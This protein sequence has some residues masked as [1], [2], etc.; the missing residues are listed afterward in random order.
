M[1]GDGVSPA[2]FDQTAACHPFIAIPVWIEEDVVIV[3]AAPELLLARDRETVLGLDCGTKGARIMRMRAHMA[4]R[5]EHA[6]DQAKI[7]SVAQADDLFA[8]P[9]GVVR[10][11]PGGLLHRH[12]ETA[13]RR[14]LAAD[15]LPPIE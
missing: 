3:F 10:A 11:K 8:C 5:Q 12:V 2:R 9:R 13:A 1:T 6:V 7:V 14:V 4:E 15:H